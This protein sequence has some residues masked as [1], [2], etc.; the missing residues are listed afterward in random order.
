MSRSSN[1]MIALLVL[2]ITSTGCQKARTMYYNAWE[3][4]GYAKRERLVDNV[5]KVRDEQTIAQKQFASALEEFKSVVNSDGGQLEATYNK[6]KKQYDNCESQATAVRNKIQAVKNVGS[7]LFVEWQGEV[8]Q[9]K[10][11]PTLKNQ[12]QA[13]YDKTKQNYTELVAR[14]DTSAA[15]MDPVLTK[16]KNRV[17]FIKGNLN[18]QAVAG[19]KGTEV[20]L[21]NE[22]NKLISEMEKC[23]AD[24]NAFIAEQ[25]PAN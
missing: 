14:M 18:A 11:D 2:A 5:S 9:I 15:A 22:I 3:K 20:E 8:N 10:D 23:I 1:F 4:V 25:K 12:S 16:F 13:L 24:A 7:S 6:L 21:G 19:L 17:L